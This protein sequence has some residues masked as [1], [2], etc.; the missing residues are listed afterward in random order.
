VGSRERKRNHHRGTECTEI[1]REGE[2]E[3][4]KDPP[5]RHEEHK[6]AQRKMVMDS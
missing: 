2:E 1:G 6:G 3:E 4:E 5:Q